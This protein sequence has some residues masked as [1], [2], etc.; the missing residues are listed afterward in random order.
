M[1]VEVITAVHAPY[2][3]HLPAA[4]HSL[5]D[6]THT[7]WTWLVQVDGPRSSAV[8]AALTSCGATDDPRTRL[9]VNGTREGPA[10]A[11]NVALG[12]AT[13]PLI[14]N[15]DADDELEPTALAVLADALDHH[16][17]AGFAVGPARDLMSSGELVDFPLPFAAGLLPRGVLFDAWDRDA[18]RRLPVHPAGVM[19][20]RDLLVALGGWSAM[21]GMEDTALLMSAAALSPCALVGTVTLRYRR[22]RQQRSTQTSFFEGGGIR[23]R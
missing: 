22:H 7:D 4:W 6:Q 1:R 2:A 11:R 3:H 17:T 10:I 9:A 18:D 14:Q 21:H 20:R 16:P 23:F 5:R 15:L 13:A 19:W 12:R 8:L